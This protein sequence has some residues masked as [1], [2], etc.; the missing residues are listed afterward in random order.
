MPSVVVLEDGRIDMLLRM[1]DPQLPFLRSFQ[2]KARYIERG[3]RC[4]A[5]QNR[6]FYNEFRQTVALA[7][8]S[9]LK[10]IK[11]LL[12]ADTLVVTYSIQ[13]KIFSSRR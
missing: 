10:T 12:H 1:G 6:A 2:A 4:R 11:A 9:V 3:C 8:P 13:G 7:S 5:G